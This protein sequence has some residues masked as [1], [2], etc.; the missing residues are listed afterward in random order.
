MSERIIE[1][2]CREFFHLLRVPFVDVRER[3]VVPLRF[4][5]AGIIR[6]SAQEVHRPDHIVKGVRLENLCNRL[7]ILEV[8]DLDARAYLVFFLQFFDECKVFV[9]RVLELVRLQPFA[10]KAADKAVVQDEIVVVEL[11][12]LRKGV[13]V[14]GKADLINAALR[15]R[16]DES[17]RIGLVI[18]SVFK[19][20]MIVKTH[21]TPQSNSPARMRSQTAMTPC[22][23]LLGAR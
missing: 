23:R 19:V 3:V 12:K 5:C 4:D 1:T 21:G 6:P 13:R 8:A 15:R 20:H 9:K 18:R 7:L 16:A 10:L 22:S 2:R 17:L 14:L 11:L